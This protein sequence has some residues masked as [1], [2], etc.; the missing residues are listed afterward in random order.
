MRHLFIAILL[1]SCVL[2]LSKASAVPV[3]RISVF[4]LEELSETEV[5]KWFGIETGD[6]FD[7]NRLAERGF[8]LLNTLA[9]AGRPFARVD[10]ILYH[11]NRRDDG[12]E[13]ELYLFEDRILRCGEFALAGLTDEEEMELKQRFDSRPG[14]PLS[15]ENLQQDLEDGLKQLEKKGYPFVRFDLKSARLGDAGTVDLSWRTALGPQLIINE[16]QIVGNELTRDYVILREIGIKPGSVYDPEKV[17]RIADKLNKLGFFASVSPPQVFWARENEGGLLLRVEEGRSSR[18][19]GVLGYTPGTGDEGGYLTGLIDISLG[20]LLGTGRSVLAHWQ[21]RDRKT[22][23]LKFFYREPWIAGLPVSAGAGFEQLI[24]DTTYVQRD[25]DLEISM[26]V[27]D[28]FSLFTEFTRTEI[29]P[30][31]L[32]SEQL[33]IPRSR[34]LNASLGVRYDTRDDRLNPRRGIYYQTTVQSG[35]KKNLGPASVIE[36]FQLKERVDSKRYT[37][38]VEWY[39]PLHGRVVLALSLHGRQLRSNEKP[40]P[41]PDLF[42]LGGARTL[43]G[44]REDQF[45]ASSLAWSNLEFRYILGRRSRAFLF[46]DSG[47]YSRNESQGSYKTG[48]GFGFRLETGLGIMGIDYGLGQGDGLFNGKVHV[49]LVNEF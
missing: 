42:R 16:I 27:L 41:I 4:G 28:N 21:K 9:R 22:Q 18:F 32:G 29:T 31:S 35:L 45:L 23:D 15:M 43:R 12:V 49:G 10:S 8:E 3:S 5:L 19:D 38:D 1:L 24:Q 37:L 47:Y 33:G 26:P 25:L 48:F 39:A 46:Y 11:P 34:S 13:I 6:P 2:D 30:D 7:A 36:A 20:N 14:R 40:V 44:Y 17:S